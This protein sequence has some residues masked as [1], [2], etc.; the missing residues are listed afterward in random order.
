MESV[1]YNIPDECR[2]NDAACRNTSQVVKLKIHHLQHLYVLQSKYYGASTR[3][4][5]YVARQKCE[6][7]W[8]FNLSHDSFLTCNI[9]TL[10]CDMV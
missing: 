5:S 2:K 7:T 1:F 8:Y 3:H 6:L 9:N 4:G 10:A